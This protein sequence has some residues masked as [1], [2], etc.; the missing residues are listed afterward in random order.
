MAMPYKKEL[1]FFSVLKNLADASWQQ[2]NVQS[3]F[4]VLLLF[5]FSIYFYLFE[6]VTC[7]RLVLTPPL[8]PPR[9]QR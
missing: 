2:K 1:W 5:H 8:M 9:G 4:F 7:R 3:V 6:S